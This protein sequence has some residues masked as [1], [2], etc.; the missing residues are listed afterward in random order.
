M[1]TITTRTIRTES[2]IKVLDYVEMLV[3]HVEEELKLLKGYSPEVDLEVQLIVTGSFYYGTERY[4]LT[5][6]EVMVCKLYTRKAAFIHATGGAA[7]RPIPLT[8]QKR[9]EEGDGGDD[10]NNVDVTININTGGSTYPLLG[11]RA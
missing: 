6:E 7:N 11:G 9:Y 3:Q 8:V 1:S 5:D 10:E 2:A 4:I